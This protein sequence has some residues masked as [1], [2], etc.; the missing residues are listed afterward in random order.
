MAT[1][2]V[3][4]GWPVP[5]CLLLEFIGAKDDRGGGDKWTGKTCKVLVKSSLPT[6]E[7]PPF[8]GLDA[9]PVTQPCQSTEGRTNIDKSPY[10]ALT[11]IGQ[12]RL[13]GQMITVLA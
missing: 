7:S 2:P 6:I 8:Y 5:E 4:L 10:Y 9:L 12:V 1:F 13:C 3:D 11:P